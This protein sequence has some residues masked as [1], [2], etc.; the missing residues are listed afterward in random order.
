MLFLDPAHVSLLFAI[1]FVRFIVKV[2][3]MFLLSQF[4]AAWEIQFRNIAEIYSGSIYLFFRRI[5]ID[6]F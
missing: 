2:Y 3:N 1:N 5:N 6:A 4:R